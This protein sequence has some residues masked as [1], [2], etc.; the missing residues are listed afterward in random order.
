MEEKEV[1]R[2]EIIS[3]RLVCISRTFTTTESRNS[4]KENDAI[5]V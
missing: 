3:L 4:N 5:N 1:Q 2:T